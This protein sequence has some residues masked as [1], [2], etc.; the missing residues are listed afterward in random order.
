M[1]VS[2][3]AASASAAARVFV[4]LDMVISF[5]LRCRADRRRL[6][7]ISARDVFVFF[8]SIT[9]AWRGVRFAREY[10]SGALPAC[11]LL[12]LGRAAH[13]EWFE[14]RH[15]SIDD[16]FRLAGFARPP[17]VSFA[18]ARRR[19]APSGGPAAFFCNTTNEHARAARRA[20]CSAMRWASPPHR[21]RA[22]GQA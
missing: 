1:N 20:W 18:R 2:D 6:A 5:G 15:G 11:P 3:V 16:S 21:R 10:A 19:P 9:I 8:D 22:P 13:W 17:S 4:D 14:R 7:V 12:H